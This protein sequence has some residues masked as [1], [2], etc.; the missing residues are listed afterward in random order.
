MPRESKL[1][2]WNP[3]AG[4]AN[5]AEDLLRELHSDQRTEIV[6]PASREESIEIVQRRG[7]EFARVIAAGGDGTVNACV[8]GLV[9]SNCRAALGILPLGSGNDLARSLEI[10]LD[11]LAA[12]ELIGGSGHPEAVDVLRYR[13]ASH[14]GVCVN[15]LTGGNTGR[16]LNAM[17]DEMKKRWGPFCYLRG[18]VDVLRDMESYNV[19][20]TYPGG[21]SEM[22]DIINV[23]LAN[24]RTSG[25]GL[26]VSPEAQLDDGLIDLVIVQ[27]GT[28]QE[29]ASLAAEY[30]IASFLEHDLVETRRVSELILSADRPLP[31][32][33][34][35]ESVGQAPL[36]VRVLP[37]AVRIIAGA[38][39]AVRGRPISP[40]RV[41]GG[42]L[43]GA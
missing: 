34:D 22:F 2:I 17:T 1:V 18:V 20:L 37:R 29:I 13:T 15:M 9:E 5:G 3:S 16:Y 19:Q 21:G 38:T 24:G 14:S 42:A 27:E 43:H 39:P 32:T 36:R 31:L 25:G 4:S 40:A 35:G 8:T 33:A 7:G 30:V 41:R 11:P 26:S 23:F 28:P 6:T 10:P 12:W